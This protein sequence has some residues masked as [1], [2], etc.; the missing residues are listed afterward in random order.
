MI[1]DQR[2]PGNRRRRRIVLLAAALIPIAAGATLI[3]TAGAIFR[4][5]QENKPTDADVAAAMSRAGCT[6]KTFPAQ[7]REHVADIN[8][9]IR[10]NSFPPTSGPHYFAPVD[11]NFYFDP[12][13]QLPYSFQLVQI[14]LVH[15]LEHGGIVIQFGNK[16]DRATVRKL[17]DFYRED[18]QLLVAA[19]L[20]KLGERIALGAWTV[21][22][23]EPGER[24]KRGV[25]RLALCPRFAGEAFS[26]FVDAFRGRGPESP[27]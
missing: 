15:N 22:P 1:R 21:P 8:A 14:Q 25:G 4:G 24:P 13:V 23:R 3:V 12:K 10:Y 9:K 2:E 18:P 20:P 11:W 7:S 26:D 19:P 5:N 6:L 27:P 17:Y 16:I